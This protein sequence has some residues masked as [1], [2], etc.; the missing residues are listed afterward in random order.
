MDL[1]GRGSRG[2]A[3]LAVAG[4]KCREGFWRK[5]VRFF[6]GLPPETFSDASKRDFLLPRPVD[7]SRETS[8][9]VPLEIL[10]AK[11]SSSSN[12][13][14][15]SRATEQPVDAHKGKLTSSW[16]PDSPKIEKPV[17]PTGKGSNQNTKR[18][19][20]RTQKGSNLNT[21]RGQIQTQK[22]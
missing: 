12:R 22:V 14:C 8:E 17:K 7:T 16:N 13:S 3:V 4:E 5:R 21:K 19:Q 10:F 1:S 15:L 2:E 18:G 6:V 9:Y 20:I 11:S